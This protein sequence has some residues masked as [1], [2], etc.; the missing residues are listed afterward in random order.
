MSSGALGRA[1]RRAASEGFKVL[2]KWLNQVKE[3][4]FTPSTFP[5]KGERVRYKVKMPS[6]LYFNV[7]YIA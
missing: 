6:L 3:A 4:A 7:R 5:P 2:G 1:V